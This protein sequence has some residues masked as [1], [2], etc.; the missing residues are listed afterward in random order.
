MDVFMERLQQEYDCHVIPTAPTVSFH[1]KLKGESEMRVIEMANEY[2][3]DDRIEEAY[4]PWVRS[5]IITPSSYLGDVMSLCQNRRG[6]IQQRH[7]DGERVHLIYSLPL[8]E[9]ITDFY[10]QLKSITSGMHEVAVERFL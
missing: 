3:D 6:Q 10:D 4:E 9:I 2:P 5:T 1:V 7:S 8:L